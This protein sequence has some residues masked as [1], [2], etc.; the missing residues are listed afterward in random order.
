MH[1]CLESVGQLFD[2]DSIDAP[3]FHNLFDNKV[4]AVR[5]AMSNA[6]A[7]G[8]QPPI[9]PWFNLLRSCHSSRCRSVIRNLP[10]KHAVSLYPTIPKWLLELYADDFR[11]FLSLVFV[12]MEHKTEVV[13]AVAIG[14]LP[15]QPLDGTALN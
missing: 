6:A 4:E 5:D 13:D 7:Q 11:R 8:R 15:R 14:R 12:G 10:G 1:A 9:Q 2:L 3:A